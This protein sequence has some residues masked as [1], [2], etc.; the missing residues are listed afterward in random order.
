MVFESITE[1]FGFPGMPDFLAED[2][3]KATYQQMTGVELGDLTWY[4]LYNG[5]L[6][7]VVFMRTGVRSIHFGEVEK[8]D[9][10]ESLFHCKPLIERLLAGVGA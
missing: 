7:C 1:V 10:V 2:G 4:H 9:D 5:V 3:V 8:P 6:W